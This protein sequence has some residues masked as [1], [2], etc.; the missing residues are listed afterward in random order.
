MGWSASKGTGKSGAAEK[1]TRR[2]K[3][4]ECLW[5]QMPR[6][7]WGKPALDRMRKDSRRDKIETG[8]QR[9]SA[10]S[11]LTRRSSLWR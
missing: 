9:A 2:R 5:S 7:A 1:R 3:F 6:A 4:V 8:W 10:W 11:L